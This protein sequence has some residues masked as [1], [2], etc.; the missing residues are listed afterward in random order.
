[1]GGGEMIWKM[2]CNNYSDTYMQRILS[3]RV[4]LGV[5]NDEINHDCGRK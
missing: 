5:P 1:M 2:Y 4:T 3:P